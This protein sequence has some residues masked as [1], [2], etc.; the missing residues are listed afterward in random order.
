MYTQETG[1]IDAEP[2]GAAETAPTF[3]SSKDCSVR[4]TFVYN[5]YFT[6]NR[7]NAAQAAFNIPFIIM[8]DYIGTDFYGL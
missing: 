4:G 1:K 8:A 5:G 6:G 7:H 2:Y 3:V